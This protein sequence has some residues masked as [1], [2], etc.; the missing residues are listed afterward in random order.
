V[1]DRKADGVLGSWGLLGSRLVLH[2]NRVEYRPGRPRR[3]VV[4]PLRS[5]E[6]VEVVPL[7]G[8]LEIT[9]GGKRC[10]V[11][12]GAPAAAQEARDAIAA[13]LPWHRPRLPPATG[14]RGGG[15]A[16]GRAAADGDWGRGRCRG[17]RAGGAA[18]YDAIVPAG[19]AARAR[20][21]DLKEGLRR[22]VAEQG[23]GPVVLGGG[24]D[25]VG[26]AEI[27]RPGGY[28]GCACRR[29][30]TATGSS[31][32][33]RTQAWTPTRRVRDRVAGPAARPGR[34]PG[35]RP[36]GRR[37]PRRTA[38]RRRTGRH[39][40]PPHGTRA[41]STLPRRASPS[42]SWRSSARGRGGGAAEH[43]VR[44]APG[45]RAARGRGR[46]RVGRE[47]LP[48]VGVRHRGAPDRSGQSGAAGGAG[49]GVGGRAVSRPEEA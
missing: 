28:T 8:R 1:P 24:A 23:A 3:T 12:A 22:P 45:A 11:H 10:R 44:R 18:R 34:S 19:V 48:L 25:A 40:W 35:R 41:G 39:G 43:E 29:E 46:P 15:D 38:G 14:A 7:T 9:A 30:R 5:V 47:H 42:S 27:G 16:R 2:R 37:S 4:D 17:H 26:A 31:P 21:R 13:A 20:P 6:A 32:W 36:S 33:T 49:P